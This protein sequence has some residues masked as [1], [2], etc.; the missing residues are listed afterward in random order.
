M[1]GFF[2]KVKDDLLLTVQK[3]DL[4]TRLLFV[5]F[6]LT[7]F[8][9][10]FLIEN[11]NGDFHVLR[12]LIAVLNILVIGFFMVSTYVVT[13]YMK[14]SIIVITAMSFV[15]S[16]GCYFTNKFRGIPLYFTDLYSIGTAMGVAGNYDYTFPP[17]LTVQLAASV[18]LI[19]AA[20]FLKERQRLKLKFRM[21]CLAVY[22]V[23][24]GLFL[25]IFVF[26]SVLASWNIKVYH[27]YPQSSYRK[28]GSVISFIRS[29]QMA[30]ISRPKNYSKKNVHTLVD[31]IN[32]RLSGSVSGDGEFKKPNIIV[33]MNESFSD[34]QS[35]GA[36]PTSEEVL[37]FINSLSENTVKGDAYVSIYG[38]RTADS[39][40]EFLTGH[41]MY[42]LPNI[43]PYQ[44]LVKEP[45]SGFTTALINQGYKN[46]MAMHPYIPTGYSRSQAYPLLGFETFLS[47]AD[48]PDEKSLHLREWISDDADV[49]RIISEYEKHKQNYDSPFYMF[50]VTMQ[51][52]GP[53]DE[54][55]DNFPIDVKITDPD[56]YDDEAERYINL[57]HLSDA[58]LKTLVD[59]FSQTEDDTVLVF[60][61]DHRPRLSDEFYEK[62]LGESTKLL[63]EDEDMELYQV[64]FVIWANY[65]IE[66]S[67][68]E[69]IS[70]NYL[71]ARMFEVCHMEAPPYYRYL[72]ELRKE[73]PVITSNGFLG[74]DGTF[75]DAGEDV[76]V[77]TPYDELLQEYSMLQYN[78]LIDKKNRVE[79]FFD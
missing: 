39:E 66:E 65:D 59:Y 60:F 75:Y 18:L 10:F 29:A 68:D 23:C 9:N 46:V 44:F 16:A 64:P 15:F 45:V 76:S 61:G 1:S 26:S 77:S 4:Q 52:H 67:T 51:N 11:V 19:A 74:K 6:V 27:F 41:T 58:S 20:I 54:D 38:G 25:Y 42:F 56:C 14:I 73:V 30:K 78:N 40:F 71:A 69:K 72:N 70:L 31:E 32:T 37:P 33:V 63:K 47:E 34:L 79:N 7:P 24:F 35:L 13:N 12:H 28:N 50:N 55:Y 53:Y 5:L 43:I 8:I 17:Q 62:I 57:A 22:G 48:F 21:P 36:I 49:K 3:L 2:T